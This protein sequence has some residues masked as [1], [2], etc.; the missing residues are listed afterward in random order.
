MIGAVI[1]DYKIV[2]HLGEGSR[3]QVFRA[4]DTTLEHDVT[5]KVLHRDLTQDARRLQHFRSEAVRLVQLNHPNVA[6]FY[7]LLEHQGDD[8]VVTEYVDGETFESLLRRQ[9]ALPVRVAL[10]FFCQILQGFEHAHESGVIHGDV[11]LSNVMLNS[12]GVVKVTDFGVARALRGR[13]LTRTG[14]GIQ[15]LEYVSPEQVRGEEPDERSDVYSLGIL[16]HRMATGRAPLSHPLAT[17]L[18]E[19]VESAIER[20]LEKNPSARFQQVR[21]MRQVLQRALEQLPLT[22]DLIKPQ[23]RLPRVEPVIPALPVLPEVYSPYALPTKAVIDVEPARTRLTPQALRVMVV[24][25]AALLL[26]AVLA[27]AAM[28]P[29]SLTPPS[30]SLR[31]S[32][33]VPV[34]SN[35]ND[36]I[37]KI[38]PPE[39]VKKV[40]PKKSDDSERRNAQPAPVV[41]TVAKRWTRRISYDKM[42]QKTG[43]L[44]AGVT[45]IKQKG[46]AGA[47]RVTVEITYRDGREVS[48]RTINEKVTRSPVPEIVLVGTAPKKQATSP[49]QSRWRGNAEPSLPPRLQREPS[50]PPRLEREPPLPPSVRSG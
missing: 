2:E 17:G 46:R 9:G 39:K 23:M 14:G 13:L 12:S 35:S 15:A 45:R 3:G 48:R 44:P 40:E 33:A 37:P 26:V 31:P 36:V 6:A 29:K 42:E 25:G 19:D 18:P 1:G 21:N 27:V 41:T 32:S 24:G 30:D 7:G 47:K 10:E 34:Q 8:Y 20:A 49:P 43:E 11:K 16:L 5:I 4:I 50:L 22:G 28:L 38:S